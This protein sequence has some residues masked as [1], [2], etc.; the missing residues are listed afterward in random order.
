MPAVSSHLSM[1]PASQRFVKLWPFLLHPFSLFGVGALSFQ[2]PC[3][4][5]CSSI[6]THFSFMYFLLTSLHLCLGRP[7]FQCPSTSMFS[8]LHLLQFSSPHG[9]YTHLSLASL[10]FLIKALSHGLFVAYLSPDTVTCVARS[11]GNTVSNLSWK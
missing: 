4:P 11:P 2:S 6:F 3:S 5:V 10:I 1:M 8:L 7:M 9:L